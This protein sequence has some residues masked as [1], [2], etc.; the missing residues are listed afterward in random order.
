MLAERV[1]PSSRLR[2]DFV[3]FDRDEFP[4]VVGEAARTGYQ[5]AA[6]A[7]LKKILND[8]PPTVKYGIVATPE[9]IWLYTVEGGRLSESPIYLAASDVLSEYDSEFANKEIYN[10]YLVTLME[11]WLRDI[12]Y[13]WKNEIPPKLSA[14]E[15][16]GIAQAIEGGTT[17]PEARF[18]DSLC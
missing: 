13:R 10:F 15:Q 9:L 17:R 12:A 5:Q 14:V 8:A 6:E 2:A 18:N 7:H 11:A 16:M 1:R 3:A 4:V